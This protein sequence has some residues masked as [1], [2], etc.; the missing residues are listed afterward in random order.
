[1]IR[2]GILRLRFPDSGVSLLSTLSLFKSRHEGSGTALGRVRALLGGVIDRRRE[3]RGVETPLGIVSS[4][5]SGPG[6]SRTLLVG[7]SMRGGPKSQP[8][9][10]CDEVRE[11]EGRNKSDLI[12][13]G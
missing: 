1:M 11:I 3:V 12:R 13:N 7:R 4:S 8:D 2:G 6:D 9:W 10:C 5:L